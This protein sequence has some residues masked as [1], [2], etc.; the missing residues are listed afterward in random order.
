MASTTVDPTAVVLDVLNQFTNYKRWSLA[1]KNYL[2]AEDLWDVVAD[3]TEPPK[4][5]EPGFKTWRKN[6]A[7]ALRTI[8]NCCGTYHYNFIRKTNSAKEAWDTLAKM[9]E[10]VFFEI[11]GISLSLSNKELNKKLRSLVFPWPRSARKR[12]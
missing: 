5:G 12:G 4:E 2:L 3:T 1:V 6:N 11:T 7:R 9:F 10:P 8:Q